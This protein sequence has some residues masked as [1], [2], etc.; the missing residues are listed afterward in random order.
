MIQLVR[1]RRWALGTLSLAI[2]ACTM[3]TGS[4]PAG[5]GGDD[6]VGETGGVP[7]GEGGTS[8]LSYPSGGTSAV[9]TGGFPVTGARASGGMR[10]TGG[11]NTGPRSC[12]C[13]C[14]CGSCSGAT[15]NGS[16]TKSC[17]AGDPG[18]SDCGP[19]CQ[20][21]CSSISCTL[22]TLASGACK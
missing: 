4:K 1:W 8:G 10:A 19:V 12:S 2:A 13:A 7:P 11:V 15:T 3:D 9:P 22:M 21:F 6:S 20:A 16:T 18:C 17:G 5:D 14:Y